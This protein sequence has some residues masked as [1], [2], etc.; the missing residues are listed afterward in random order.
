MA[1]ENPFMLDLRDNSTKTIQ[2]PDDKLGAIKELSELTLEQLQEA[3]VSIFPSPSSEK[4]E[5]YCEEIKSSV[6]F[7]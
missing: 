6:H 7:V 3:G 2:I 1:S 4:F 5:K